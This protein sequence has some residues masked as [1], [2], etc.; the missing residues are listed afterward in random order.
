MLTF[1]PNLFLLLTQ[2]FLKAFLLC[3]LLSLEFAS[4]TFCL[5]LLLLSSFLEFA[6]FAGLILNPLLLLSF[7]FFLCKS[8]LQNS[9]CFF[10]LNQLLLLSKHL[11]LLLNHP[12]F[13]NPFLFLDATL[14]L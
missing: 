14:L 6:L 10:F 11:L 2:F 4:S 9:V 7:S 3:A 1:Q 13:V 8:F 5:A 12:H